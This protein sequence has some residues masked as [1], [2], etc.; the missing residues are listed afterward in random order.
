MVLAVQQTHCH[1][2]TFTWWLLRLLLSVLRPPPTQPLPTL[3]PPSRPNCAKQ[4]KITYVL[5]VQEDIMLWG[6]FAGRETRP[7]QVH[8]AWHLASEFMPNFKPAKVCTTWLVC[9]YLHA[10]ILSLSYVQA[11]T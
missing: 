5:L 8:Q 10:I 11:C 4:S 1:A 2:A 9:T 7:Q 3:L 6:G